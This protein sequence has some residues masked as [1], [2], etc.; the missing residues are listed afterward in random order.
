MGLI[1]TGNAN[2]RSR[3]LALRLPGG[4]EVE[5]SSRAWYFE[6]VPVQYKIVLDE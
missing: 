5:C 3:E 2:G 6:K 1:K 4:G